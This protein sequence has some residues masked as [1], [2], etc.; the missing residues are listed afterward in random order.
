MTAL[1]TANRYESAFERLS[2]AGSLLPKWF[3]LL[4]RRA[5][6]RFEQIGF[7]TTKEEDW[8]YTSVAP[9]VNGDFEPLATD[10]GDGASINIGELAG[11][12]YPESKESQLVFINGRLTRTLS[13]LG[14]EIL[15]SGV[16]VADIV[17]A[18][19]GPWEPILRDHLA[20]GIDEEADAFIALNTAFMESGAFI[21]IPASVKLESP[22]QLL[23]FTQPPTDTPSVTFPRSFI[24]MEE[25]SEATIIENHVGADQAS[26][27]TNAVV[28]V[29]VGSN[30]RLTHHKVQQESDMAFHVAATQARLGRDSH[31]STTTISLGAA[32]AR[33]NIA[34]RLPE[35]GAETNVDGLYIVGD[36]QHTDTHSL[37]DH[38]APNCQSHQLYKGIL[39]GKSRAVFNGRVFVHKDAQKTDAF[40]TNR[41]L[42][43]SSAARVDT[44]PQLEIFADDV[45]CSHGATVGQ[46]EEEAFFY[47]LSRGLPVDL[48]RNLLIYGFA[49]EVVERIGVES[50]KAQ[51]NEIIINRLHARFDR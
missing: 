35:S 42:L 51:L 16:V 43:L 32:L 34:V 8:K 24:F 27:F 28:E 17:E 26:Y 44:K 1:A 45:K 15:R 29:F 21:L 19:S 4:R 23:F 48:A 9:I 39:D 11:Y 41:N 31:Y 38:I 25:G 46:L 49:E 30:A 22:L 6:E 7:P 37:I 18:L 10:V 14:N 3:E 40:Q 12:T 5:F 47:L 50:I 13:T 2:H 36:K 33:H 20:R